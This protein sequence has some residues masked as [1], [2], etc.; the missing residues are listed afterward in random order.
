[1]TRETFCNATQPGLEVSQIPNKTIVLPF[2]EATY[3]E[4]LTDTAAYTA[5]VQSWIDAHPELFPA[6]IGAGWSL[7]GFTRESVKQ[8]IRLRRILTTADQEVWH[9]R[10]AFV[11]PYMTPT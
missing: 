6:T 1:M 9:I 4:L 10:P 7:N 2:D 11:M 8:G 5:Y 3:L